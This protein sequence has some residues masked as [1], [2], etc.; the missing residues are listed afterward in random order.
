MSINTT[1]GVITYT[2][3][4]GYVGTDSFTYT[5]KDNDGT[6]SNAATVNIDVAAKLTLT[7]AD[8]AFIADAQGYATALEVDGCAGADYISTSGSIAVRSFR[9]PTRSTAAKATTLS[10]PAP[11]MTFW[12]QARR[13]LIAQRAAATT[14]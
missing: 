13:R 5:V 2:P 9:V 6:V 14:R 4:A 1:T 3:T 7:S 11:A 10:S 12:T 8:E